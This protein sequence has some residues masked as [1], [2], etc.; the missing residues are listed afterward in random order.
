MRTRLES[1][2]AVAVAV[3]TVCPARQDSPKK[4]PFQHRDDGFFALL[5]DHGQLDLAR[6]NI[7]HGIR[8]I[9]LRKENLLLGGR[10][11]RFAVPQFAEEHLR[12]E[13]R[14]SFA[15]HGLPLNQR[16]PRETTLVRII[17][18]HYYSR[19]FSF[20]DPITLAGRCFKSLPVEYGDP[21]CDCA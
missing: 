9:P 8:R 15:C 14:G 16:T 19:K 13:R 12:I 21:G 3:R 10:Q 5:R 4:A 18:L 7:E 2:T 20:D 11:S 17:H 1:S 6:L